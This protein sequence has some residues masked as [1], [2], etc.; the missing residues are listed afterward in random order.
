LLPLILVLAAT[1]ALVAAANAASAPAPAKQSSP[2]RGPAADDGV[3]TTTTARRRRRRRRRAGCSRF[4]RQAGGFGAGPGAKEPV[5]I[6]R[7]TIRVDRFGEIG[8]R[9]TCRLKRKCVGAILVEGYRPNAGQNLA[10]G[11]ADLRIPAGKTRKVYV[12]VTRKGRRYLRRHGCDR[13]VFATVP[14]KGDHPVSVSPEFTL[15]PPR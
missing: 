8:I 9:A 1:G 2:S 13:R 4:C 3:A 10:Y 12:A 14:L 11:R 5:R 15:L 6:R 7:Q